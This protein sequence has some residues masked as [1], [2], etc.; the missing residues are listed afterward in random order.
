MATSKKIWIHLFITMLWPQQTVQSSCWSSMLNG[1]RPEPTH[2]RFNSAYL[3]NKFPICRKIYS[4]YFSLDK[5]FPVDHK[6]PYCF[7]KKFF[8]KTTKVEIRFSIGDPPAKP[9]K[10][11]KK[12]S[13]SWKFIE[14]THSRRSGRGRGSGVI[15]ILKKYTTW[16]PSLTWKLLPRQHLLPDCLLVL[17]ISPICAAPSWPCPGGRT[18]PLEA[19]TWRPGVQA[20]RSRP[21]R[22]SE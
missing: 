4:N 18:P 21:C 7:K 15:I 1:I 8:L 13:S 17:L 9:A 3:Q 10:Q 11:K 5:T 12:T 22:R 6:S 19:W 14:V 20:S 16:L 2:K